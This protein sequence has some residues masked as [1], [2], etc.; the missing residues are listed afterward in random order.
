MGPGR[1]RKS[2]TLWNPGP[3]IGIHRQAKPHS[4]IRPFVNLVVDQPGVPAD[5]GT[6][7]GGA[8]IGLGPDRVVTVAEMVGDIGQ[9]LDDRDSESLVD[10]CD[11]E[12]LAFLPWAPLQDTKAHGPLAGVAARHSASPLQIALAWLLARSPAMLP[13]PGTGS[14]AHLEENVAAAGI[15]LGPDDV[16]ELT[17]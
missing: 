10:L 14:V 17:G 6:Q 8:E 16:R 2:R 7:P 12:T 4:R 13:I 5:R 15:K 9:H 3:K 11:Q 1:G